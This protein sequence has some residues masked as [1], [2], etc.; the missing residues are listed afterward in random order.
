MTKEIHEQPV[1]M[2]EALARYAP[3]GLP[4]F[5]DAL[6][7]TRFDRVVMVACGTG[8][9]S[10]LTAKYWFEQIARLPCEVDVASEFRYREPPIAPRTLA[11]F[12]SQSGETA[13][14]L[15]ARVLTQEHLIYPQAVAQF[16]AQSPTRVKRG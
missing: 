14:T 6:D 13:D 7:F 11:I 9:Y 4:V 10:C 5:P 1:V 3:N 12:V 8:F 2:A 16:L 15:A